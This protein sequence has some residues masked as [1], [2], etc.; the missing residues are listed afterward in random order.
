MQSKKVKISDEHEARHFQLLFFKTCFRES[1]PK[2]DGLIRNYF[3]VLIYLIL[4]DY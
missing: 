2:S 3:Q 1:I 4:A